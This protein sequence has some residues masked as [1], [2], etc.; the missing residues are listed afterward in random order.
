[1]DTEEATKN[2]LPV[3]ETPVIDEKSG[4]PVESKPEMPGVT[5]QKEDI[6][7]EA[8]QVFEEQGSAQ[9]SQPTPVPSRPR[10]S[11]HFGTVLFVIIL[12]GLGVWLS[13]RLRSFFTPSQT[14]PV[15]VPTVVPG[16]AAPTVAASPSAA[17][18]AS[19]TTEQVISGATKTVIAGLSYKLP[20]GVA[21]PVCDG[22]SCPSQGTYLPGGTRFTVAPR[23]KGQLLPDF[24]GAILTD[25]NGKEFIMKQTTVGGVYGYQYTG[26]FTGST[27]GGYT[28]TKMRGILIPVNDKLAVEFNHFSPAGT[29][30][31]FAF[32]DA[33]F[34]K[35]IA[36]F[37][38]SIP[39]ASSS[40]GAG[41][42]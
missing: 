30:T 31:D 17:P 32:D 34:D 29:T 22:G 9:Q 11:F 39:A 33:L 40:A 26:D 21:A 12:F 14:A 6:I 5:Y 35:I 8:A 4:E 27:G 16:A 42:S 2:A 20:P 37:A 23:G 18:V 25:A 15:V 13:T 19:W 38:S 3:E 7:P 24:R 10:S 36:S 41:G 28:F 1:M